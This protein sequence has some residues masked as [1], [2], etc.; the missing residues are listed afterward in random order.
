MNRLLV[1]TIL[2]LLGATSVGAQDVPRPRFDPMGDEP[3]M[4][5]PSASSSRKAPK[6]GAVSPAC[7]AVI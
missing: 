4:A 3:A 7:D 1:L 2:F 5:G 6:P